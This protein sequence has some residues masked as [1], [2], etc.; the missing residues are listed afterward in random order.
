MNKKVFKKRIIA[1]ML[2]MAFVLGLTGC[3]NNSS[4]YP[5]YVKSMMTAYYLGVPNEY[6]KLTGADQDE[7]ESVYLQN[8]TRLADNLSQYY[9][10]D[11]SRDAELGPAMV[12]LAKQIYSKAKFTVGNVYK[13]NTIYYVDVKIQP[14]DILNQTNEEVYAYVDK[15]NKAVDNGDYND[16][17][18]EEYEY[19]FAGGVIGILAKAVDNITYA[20]E[21]TVKVR[22]IT[23]DDTYYVGNEDVRNIDMAI[24]ATDVEATQREFELSSPSTATDALPAS[25]TD[26]EE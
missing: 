21:Q 17:T 9:G 22:I 19:E 6:V 24:L 23:S 25:S 20:E 2:C 10:L 18:K 15:F 12:D 14:I 16:Y 8:V 3:G 4:R 11:I 26:E 1:V 7:V 13:D 5:A